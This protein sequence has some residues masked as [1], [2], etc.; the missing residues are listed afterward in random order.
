METATIICHYYPKPFGLLGVR[1]EWQGPRHAPVMVSRQCINELKL[2]PNPDDPLAWRNWPKRIEID[3]IPLRYLPDSENYENTFIHNAA[4]YVRVDGLAWL[5]W[6]GWVMRRYALRAFWFVYERGI[7][8]LHVWGLVRR[9]ASQRP[10]WRDI[11]LFK[12]RL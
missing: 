1:C 2:D 9:E 12:K 5:M 4:L 3:G 10:S 11:K 8:T 7:L 6:V